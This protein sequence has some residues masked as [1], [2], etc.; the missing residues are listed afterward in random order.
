MSNIEQIFRVQLLLSTGEGQNA[1]RFFDNFENAATYRLAEH[2]FI[3]EYDHLE[4]EFCIH[5]NHLICRNE[6]RTIEDAEAAEHSAFD[7]LSEFEYF[8]TEED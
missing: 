5:S 7:I 6:F 4:W 8:D 1:D 2:A 3:Y